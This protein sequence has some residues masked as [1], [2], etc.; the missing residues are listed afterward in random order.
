MKPSVQNHCLTAIT[1]LGRYNKAKAWKKSVDES[2]YEPIRPEGEIDE[3]VITTIQARR[4]KK[5]DLAK[6]RISDLV[7]SCAGFRL[8]ID[9]ALGR[10][11]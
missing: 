6:E 5:I 2:V 8:T 1:S 7:L 3:K 4:Q 9:Y 11:Y 10:C